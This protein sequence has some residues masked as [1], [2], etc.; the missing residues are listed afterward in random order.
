MLRVHAASAAGKSESESKLNR[1]SEPRVEMIRNALASLQPQRL[2][3]FD[4]SHLHAGHAGARDGKGHFRVT[5]IADCF[6]GM[7]QLKR[8]RTVFTALDALMKSDIHALSID[9]RTPEE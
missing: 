5:I 6:R 7:A 1:M 8:H 9:A 3:V 4:D 2:E